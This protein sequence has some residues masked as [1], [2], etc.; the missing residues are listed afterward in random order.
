M[1]KESRVEIPSGSGNFYRYEYVD[2]ATRYL[3]PMGSA[4]PISE[5]D[6]LRDVQVTLGGGE[7]SPH[8]I[9]GTPGKRGT[10]K[11][12]DEED[13]EWDLEHE[14]GFTHDLSDD[15]ERQ[16]GTG[17]L[18]DKSGDTVTITEWIEGT[19]YVE[20]FED[21]DATVIKR[22][23][24]VELKRLL[25]PEERHLGS[26]GSGRDWND[27]IDLF[28]QQDRAKFFHDAQEVHRLEEELKET[29]VEAAISWMGH[30]GGSEDLVS[31][32]GD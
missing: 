13:I 23:A 28:K 29:V 11:E 27:A 7:A 32:I 25:D 6:F 12:P 26:Y 15:T 17:L 18:I 5:Q 8:D 21:P 22:Q 19:G 20:Q 14:W 4:P 10:Y 16:T 3:G 2:G 1:G 24:T 9:M 31:E 30:Y